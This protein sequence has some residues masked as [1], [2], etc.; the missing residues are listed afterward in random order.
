MAKF[1]TR[2][3]RRLEDSAPAVQD[4]VFQTRSFT[5]QPKQSAAN[6][7]RGHHLGEIS[8]YPVQAKLS[9]GKSNDPYEQ[10]ADQMA[11][12][13]VNGLDNPEATTHS[14]IQP[15]VQTKSSGEKS[16]SN[17]N[18]EQS[19][20]QSRGS[21]EALPDDTRESMERSFGTDF[22]SV[23]VHTDAQADSMNRSIQAR[24]FTTGQDVYFRQGEYKPSDR[25]GKELLVH[26]LTHV[27]QQTGAGVQRKSLPDHAGALVQCMKLSLPWKKKPKQATPPKQTLPPSKQTLPPYS[28]KANTNTVIALLADPYTRYLFWSYAKKE[29][30]TENIEC[31]EAIRKYQSLPFDQAE[32]E[33]PLIFSTYIGPSAAR[34]VNLENTTLVRTIQ[35]RVEQMDDQNYKD[36]FKEV[37]GILL[38]VM[39]DTLSRFAG[40]EVGRAAAKELFILGQFEA[41]NDNTA[42]NTSNA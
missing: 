42:G 21:G 30:A 27:V 9:I 33:A 41:V 25:S 13:V 17:D 4:S 10:E 14:E 2:K 3:K 12:K 24:A 1:R 40:T 38:S 29:Y 20:E 11:A 34:E 39:A 5:A 36:V 8:V 35:N 19:I 28:L 7:D 22:S 32:Q 15:L 31:F 18:L 6:P 26:E 16:E 37:P 23:R